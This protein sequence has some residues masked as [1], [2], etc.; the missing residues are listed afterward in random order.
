[1][2]YVYFFIADQQFL[3]VLLMPKALHSCSWV[4][5]H[6]IPSPSLVARLC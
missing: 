6:R 3:N 1:M 4:L 2:S 5:V